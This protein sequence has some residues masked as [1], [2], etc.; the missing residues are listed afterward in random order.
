MLLFD[1]SVRLAARQ[2]CY[3][4]QRGHKVKRESL[5]LATRTLH[6]ALFW[7]Q[8]PPSLAGMSQG[9]RGTQTHFEDP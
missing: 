6:S 4:S 8:S 1:A 9:I 7:N 3:I 2:R 5:R